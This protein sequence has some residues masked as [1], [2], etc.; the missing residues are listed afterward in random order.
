MTTR[1]VRP[2]RQPSQPRLLIAAHPDVHRLPRHPKSV[3]DLGHRHPRYQNFHNG[4]IALFHDAQLHE[5][6]PRPLPRRRSRHEPSQERDCYPSGEASVVRISRSQTLLA[7]SAGSDGGRRFPASPSSEPC[8][9][10][11]RTPARCLCS[12]PFPTSP[13]RTVYVELHVTG[14]EGVRYW[15]S[16][17]GG[18]AIPSGRCAPAGSPGPAVTR[19]RRPLPAP[20]SCRGEAS[21]TGADGG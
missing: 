15:R 12:G 14:V 8:L 6:Q 17:A 16:T 4:V 7:D 20:L 5:H 1:P 11:G 3:G 13:H 21:A 9:P 10:L 2:I 18:A 19:G